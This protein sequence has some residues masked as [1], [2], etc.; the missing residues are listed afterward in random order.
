MNRPLASIYWGAVRSALEDRHDGLLAHNLDNFRSIDMSQI[1]VSNMFATGVPT[2]FSQGF[3]PNVP[4]SGLGG[5]FGF[6]SPF[7]PSMA[8]NFYNQAA[9]GMGHMFSPYGGAF[10]GGFGASPYGGFATGSPW[11]GAYGYQG[12]YG[13]DDNDGYGQGF[14]YGFGPQAFGGYG[15]SYGAYGR[16]DRFSRDAYGPQRDGDYRGDGGWTGRGYQVGESGK[17]NIDFKGGSSSNNNEVEYRV[18][19]GDWVSAGKSKDMTGKNLQI[20]APPG[21]HVQFRIKSPDG[22]THQAGSRRNPNGEDGAKVSR[23]DSGATRLGFEDWT[24]NDYNDAIIELS[25]GRR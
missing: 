21:A 25:D 10:G 23:T 15:Q 8:G 19:G 22:S 2:T 14:G 9:N 3:I 11:G 6:A 13:R 20:S 24:D 4:P 5:G 17:V 7:M 1:F 18:G 16:G 12:G